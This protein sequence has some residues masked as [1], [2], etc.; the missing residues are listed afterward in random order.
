[1]SQ[2]SAERGQ[3][4]S[5]DEQESQSPKTTVTTPLPWKQLMIVLMMRLAEPI[6]FSLIFPFIGDMIWDL[7]ATHDRG[8][9]GMYAGIVESL[10]AGVQTLTV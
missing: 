8:E 5:E 3:E 10:F 2:P 9:I 4:G 7:G 6:S 1:M